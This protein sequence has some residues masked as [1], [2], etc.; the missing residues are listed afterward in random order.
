TGKPREVEM[1]VRLN[2]GEY[3][4]PAPGDLDLPASGE[5]LYKIGGQHF[6]GA[7]LALD[8]IDIDGPLVDEW[9]PAA[10]QKLFPGV[11]IEPLP[12]KVVERTKFNGK[13]PVRAIVPSLPESDLRRVIEQFATRA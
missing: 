9:P 8:W 5:S 2:E 12:A 10:M 4:Y 13:A 7:G 1:V 6:T 3:L 11:A